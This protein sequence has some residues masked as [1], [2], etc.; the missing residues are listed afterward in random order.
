MSLSGPIFP[1]VMNNNYTMTSGEFLNFIFD[2]M[3]YF[4]I[5]MI[6]NI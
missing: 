4:R 3:I 5:L 6:P 1:E 2:L